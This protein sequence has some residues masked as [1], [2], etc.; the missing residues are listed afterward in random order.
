MEIEVLRR[1]KTLSGMSPSNAE[2][3]YLDVAKMLQFY[4]VDFHEVVAKDG[5]NY[6]LGL[7][8]T[9]V[10]VFDKD[11]LVGVLFWQ[12]IQAVNFSN[13]KLTIVLDEHSSNEV[14]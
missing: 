12:Y 3:Q 1:Y 10:V 2:R 7:T 14:I 8:P 9:G 13:R 4:G 5:N 11:N 6:R